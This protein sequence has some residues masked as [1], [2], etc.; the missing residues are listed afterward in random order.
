MDRKLSLRVHNGLL[1]EASFGNL[2]L[3]NFGIEFSDLF[4][5]VSLTEQSR[6]ATIRLREASN[7]DGSSQATYQI[8]T[9]EGSFILIAETVQVDDR[10]I[11]V[12]AQLHSLRDVYIQD[13]VIRM[14]FLNTENLK[15]RISSNTFS[16]SGT[17]KYRQFKTTE[18]SIFNDDS[19]AQLSSLKTTDVRDAETHFYVRDIDGFWIVHNR[20]FPRKECSKYSLRWITRHFWFVGLPVFSRAIRNVPFLGDILWYRKE[21]LGKTAIELQLIGLIE[22]KANQWIEQSVQISFK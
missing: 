7:E 18:A 12:S 5:F 14:K 17:E 2:Q 4:S 6:M 21:R 8:E 22:L 3:E 9:A 10:S 15:A 20:L 1:K 19:V 16:H 11:K 13:F